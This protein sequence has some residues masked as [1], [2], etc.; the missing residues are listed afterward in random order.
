[1][2]LS[3]GIFVASIGEVWG[4]FLEL[5]DAP[6]ISP[7]LTIIQGLYCKRNELRLSSRISTHPLLSLGFWF[8]S[9]RMRQGGEV[10]IAKA[11]RSMPYSETL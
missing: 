11:G 6:F 10:G 8:L 5:I 7:A 3:I 4:K 2:C 1:M 9:F